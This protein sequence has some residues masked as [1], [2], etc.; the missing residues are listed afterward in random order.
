MK[1][2]WI[3]SLVLVALTVVLQAQ[4]EGMTWVTF[5]EAVEMKDNGDTRP[6]FI[7]VYTDWC[8]WCKRMDATT[9]NN[10]EVAAYMNEHFINVKLDG[11]YKED[12]EFK[13]TTFKF[14]EKGRRGYH[15]LA[16]TLLQGKLSYPTV[17]FLDK[18]FNLVQPLPGY[19][20][21]QDFLPIANYIGGEHY[22]TTPWEEFLAEYKGENAPE[23]TDEIE[24]EESTQRVRRVDNSIKN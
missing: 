9:F 6:V 10:P 18:E 12:I 13:G 21:P 2:K 4:S 7:D 20:G 11:E 19:R 15:E 24:E 17:V 1:M 3:Y 8:G 23:I 22:K 5:E 14:V 16:A